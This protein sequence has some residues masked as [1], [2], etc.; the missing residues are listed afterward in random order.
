M[1]ELLEVTLLYDFYG[2]LLTARQRQMFELYYLNDLSLSEIAEQLDISRQAVR[3]SIKHSKTILQ[4]YEDKL[5]LV[6]KFLKEKEAILKIVDI[7][8]RVK[9]ISGLPN[10]ITNYMDSIKDLA[11]EIID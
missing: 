6:A 4:D 9:N 5:N 8:D 10:G 1:D 2:E 3:D 7:V 11:D